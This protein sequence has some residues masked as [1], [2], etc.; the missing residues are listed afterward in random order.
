[1]TGTFAR[2]ARVLI[3]DGPHAEQHGLAG[4]TALVV[5]AS[6][7]DA[8]GVAV[9]ALDGVSGALG[10]VPNTPDCLAGFQD[11]PCLSLDPGCCVLT[12]CSACLSLLKGHLGKALSAAKLS[13]EQGDRFVSVW[14]ELRMK[15][16]EQMSETLRQARA[17]HAEHRKDGPV[18]EVET[19]KPCRAMSGAMLCELV[20]G[21]EGDHR[22]LDDLTWPQQAKEAPQASDTPQ[23]VPTPPGD[24]DRV[25]PGRARR[26]KEAPPVPAAPP[27]PAVAEGSSN[28]GAVAP[29]AEGLQQGATAIDT[30]TTREVNHE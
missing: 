18:V 14:N 8:P 17:W 1:M 25:T 23:V 28:G 13:P 19:V 10:L 27:E 12:P 5:E 9:L 4:R 7:A 15:T 21:H 16:R 26:K 24:K 2:G 11:R 3:L 6:H 29:E 20:E 22:C 30:A